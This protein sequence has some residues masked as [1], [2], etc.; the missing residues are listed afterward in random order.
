MLGATRLWVTVVTESG[1]V[2]L[3][4]ESLARLMLGDFRQSSARTLGEFMSEEPKKSLV[5]PLLMMLAFPVSFLFVGYGNPL[6]VLFGGG[7]GLIGLLRVGRHFSEN[8][9]LDS[10]LQ[11]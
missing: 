10:L 2:S 8:W 4:T 1:S 11:H 3:Y 9:S 7:M 5:G 6:P